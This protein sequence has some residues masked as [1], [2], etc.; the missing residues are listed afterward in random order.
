VY[1]WFRRWLELGLFDRLLCDVA[2]LRRRAAGRTPEPS[3]GIIDTQSVKCIPVRGPRGYDA[4]KKVL[5]HGDDL[6]Q[7]LIHRPS[8][9]VLART[10]ARIE[11]LIGFPCGSNRLRKPSQRPPDYRPISLCPRLHQQHR[12]ARGLYENL[13]RIVAMA[14]LG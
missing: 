5:G 1:G 8:G 3:L 6:H 9:K 4:A 10:H 13:A 12:A 14:P 7:K 11:I 2:L